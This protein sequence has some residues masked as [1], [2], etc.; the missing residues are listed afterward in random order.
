MQS[1]KHYT[2]CEKRLFLHILK[3]F[4]RTIETK[5]SDNSTLQRKEEAWR[6]I[7]SEYNLSSVISCERSIA[8]L[9]KF[10]S[11]LKAQQRD[12]LTKERQHVLR[13]GGGPPLNSTVEPDP[14]IAA[15]TPELMYTAPVLYTSNNVEDSIINNYDIDTEEMEDRTESYYP[16]IQAITEPAHASIPA[17]TEPAVT[18]ET[19]ETIS[20]FETENDTAVVET[21]CRKE[22]HKNELYN[23]KIERMRLKVQQEK[24]KVSYLRQKYEKKLKILDKKLKAAEHTT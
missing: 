7:H 1:R 11:N 14:E 13:T 9:K 16:S 20:E 21:V 12:V 15:L 17:I 2:D 5:K 19:F 3:K 23:L 24:L 8:Q 10:W 22:T 6:L 4:S 18:D